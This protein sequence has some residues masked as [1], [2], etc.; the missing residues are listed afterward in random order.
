M[1]RNYVFP[2]RKEGY[3]EDQKKD[4]LIS[5]FFMLSDE[6]KKDVIDHKAEYSYDEI[7]SKL[8]VTGFEKGVNFSMATEDTNTKEVSEKETVSFNFDNNI[9]TNLPDWV[10]AV[11]EQEKLI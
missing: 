5:K 4:E 8:A 7:K 11:K 6:D 3:Y 1:S 9:D 10:Q 2:F